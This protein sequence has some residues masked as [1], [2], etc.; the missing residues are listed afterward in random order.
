MVLLFLSLASVV[1]FAD[2]LLHSIQIDAVTGNVQAAVLDVVDDL[3]GR[4][5]EDLPQPPPWA[6]P[7]ASS[8]SGYIQF[9]EPRG[10]APVARTAGSLRRPALSH[11][12]ACG[13]RHHPWFGLAALAE[14]SAAGSSC[15]GRA[16]NDSRSY[17]L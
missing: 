15:A 14:R 2:H 5:E 16:L 3:P 10:L 6:V 7:I 11:W 17:R 8:R 12:R 1:F 13:G 4:S 9:A